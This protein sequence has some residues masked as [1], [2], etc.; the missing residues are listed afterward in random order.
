M[1]WSIPGWIKALV[2]VFAEHSDVMAVTGLV[3]PYELET[4]A[5]ILFERY[6]GFTRGFERHWYRG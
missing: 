5:Q 6:G 1:W 2:S 4:E 3:V